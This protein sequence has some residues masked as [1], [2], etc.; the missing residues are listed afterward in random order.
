MRELPRK[1]LLGGVANAVST[2]S[3]AIRPV[4]VFERFSIRRGFCP[5]YTISPSGKF[6]VVEQEDRNNKNNVPIRIIEKEESFI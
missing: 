4:G 2:S 3:I 6:L 5:V 1:E